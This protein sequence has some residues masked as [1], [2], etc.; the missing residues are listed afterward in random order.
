MVLRYGLGGGKWPKAPW[1]LL[2]TIGAAALGAAP[3]FALLYPWWTA[4]PWLG[5]LEISVF[6][7]VGTG[8]LIGGWVR[9]RRTL[10]AATGKTSSS[11][12]QRLW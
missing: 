8:F 5:L 1:E 3:V 11:R 9:R 7:G 2:M 12:L 4:F 6:I 10:A